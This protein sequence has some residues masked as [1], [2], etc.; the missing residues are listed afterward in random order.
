M[1]VNNPSS[2][3]ALHLLI[4]TSFLS[5][6]HAS[7][8]FLYF[9]LHL[10]RF[11]ALL[12]CRPH[13]YLQTHAQVSLLRLSLGFSATW[14]AQ[15]RACSCQAAGGEGCSAHLPLHPHLPGH[16]FNLLPHQCL[17]SELQQL[18]SASSGASQRPVS[19]LVALTH[20]TPPPWQPF[21]LLTR[22]AFHILTFVVHL[23]RLLLTMVSVLPRDVSQLL[24]CGYSCFCN[25]QGF[26]SPW[27]GNESFQSLS[28]TFSPFNILMLGIGSDAI[29]RQMLTAS[30]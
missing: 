8:H 10:P 1:H 11:A 12:F 25:D 24:C 28:E 5:I 16:P 4:L 15:H 2:L 20:L 26:T 29:T 17:Q 23:L 14:S 3:A 13:V 6:C 21:Q 30:A 9:F 19:F 7:W 18:L 22:S 27:P